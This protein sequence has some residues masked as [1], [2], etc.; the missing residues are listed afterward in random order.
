MTNKITTIISEARDK[1]YNEATKEKPY[2]IKT[3]CEIHEMLFGKDSCF[4]VGSNYRSMYHDDYASFTYYSNVTGEYFEDEWATAFACPNYSCYECKRF[5]D[6]KKE[7]LINIELF[8]STWKPY[9]YQIGEWYKKYPKYFVEV[10]K[11]FPIV[12][13]FR[14]RS[15]KGR[16]GVYFGTRK[17]NNKGWEKNMEVIYDLE[18]KEFFLVGAGYTQITD[19]FIEKY[20]KA[21][22]DFIEKENQV[23]D[24]MREFNLDIERSVIDKIFFN[25]D[26]ESWYSEMSNARYKWLERYD[27]EQDRKNYAPSEKLLQWVRDHF[28][29]VTDENEIYEIAFKINKK[30]ARY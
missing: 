2:I 30:N 21:L 29:Q 6:A 25:G 14:G 7:G 12:K 3:C 20:N 19:D 26:F 22:D 28:K 27:Y 8:N 9:E 15:N 11:R 4:L 17:V 23:N 1:A 13:V 5:E 16:T 10:K 18:T 24:R